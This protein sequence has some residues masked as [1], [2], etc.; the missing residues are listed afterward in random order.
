M[1]VNPEP[2]AFA[3]L[4]DIEPR[5][6]PVIVNV[7]AEEDPPPV[8]YTVTPAVPVVPISD[9]KIE[10]CSCVELTYVVVRINPFHRITEFVPKAPPYAMRVNPEPPPIAE[11]GDIELRMGT[12]GAIVNVRAEEA[13]PLEVLYTLTLAV[14]VVAISDARI[15]P[16]NWLELTYVVVRS[17]PF[18]RI[19]EFV[20]KFEP[21]AVRMNPGPPA[22][23]EVGD[24]EPRLE[25]IIVNVRAGEA[26]PPGVYTVTPA[27][28]VVPISDARIEPCNC[29]EST[30]VVVRSDPFHRIVEFVAKFPP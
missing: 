19:T 26:P 8:V 3:E 7:R 23:A 28:P 4:G 15:E 30:Y 13:P 5:L 27:V 12:G 24:I 16:C 21:V 25:P 6:G 1:R 18:H 9:A 2:P 17:V 22:F 14:P 10:H 11:L 20:V 29:V